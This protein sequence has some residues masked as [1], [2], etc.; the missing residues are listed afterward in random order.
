M[1]LKTLKALIENSMK[2][3]SYDE[4]VKTYEA[5]CEMSDKMLEDA[6]AELD[7]AEESIE[8]LEDGITQT[9]LDLMVALHKAGSL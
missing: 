2:Y 7:A 1:L 9:I 8:V 4:L 5:E 3:G 6:Y